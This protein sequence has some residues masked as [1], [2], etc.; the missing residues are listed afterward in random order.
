MNVINIYIYIL[1]NKG[2]F[3]FSFRLSQLEEKIKSMENGDL[4]IAPSQYLMQGYSNANVDESFIQRGQEEAV[5]NKVRDRLSSV[6]STSSTGFQVGS[7]SEGG[8]KIRRDESPDLEELFR[9][10]EALSS[11]NQNITGDLL[12]P[13][14]ISEVP[15]Q[16]RLDPPDIIAEGMPRRIS[17]VE[18]D[19][20]NLIVEVEERCHEDQEGKVEDPIVLPEHLQ[21]LVDKAMNDLLAEA[22]Q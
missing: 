19:E 13:V 12:K 16:P 20:V 21:S 4:I 22:G 3:C 18:E 2:L 8:D 6:A 7:G 9:K 1:K 11:D 17:Q 10:F 14:T 5:L 15:S